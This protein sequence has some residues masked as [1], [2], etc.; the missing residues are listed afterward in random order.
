[1]VLFIMLHM[2]NCEFTHPRLGPVRIEGIP[3]D[4]AKLLF[5]L[6]LLHE[7]NGSNDAASVAGKRLINKEARAKTSKRQRV[8]KS[9]EHLARKGILEPGIAQILKIYSETYPGEDRNHIDQVLRD[10]A[11]KT[12][13]VTRTRWG[14]F[15]LNN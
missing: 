8:L 13:L 2:L 3:E 6:D 9:M 7:M 1:M 14:R 10:L 12:D 5:E 15:R 11:N 4:I